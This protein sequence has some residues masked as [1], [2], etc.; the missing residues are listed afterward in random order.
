MVFTF[1]Q[2]N[3]AM[4]YECLF[5]NQRNDE[6]AVVHAFTTK[7]SDTQSLPRNINVHIE[8]TPKTQPSKLTALRN[9]PHLLR[10]LFFF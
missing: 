10:D 2:M 6:A 4:H 7:L 1:E 5:D 9:V 3:N 8:T